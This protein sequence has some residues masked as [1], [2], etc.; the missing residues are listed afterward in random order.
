MAI[1]LSSR[2]WVS[3]AS[4]PSDDRYPLNR[5]DRNGCGRGIFVAA[6]PL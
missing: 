3:A 4:W 6:V 2:I 5:F 1:A